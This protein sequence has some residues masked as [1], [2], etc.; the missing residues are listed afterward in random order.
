MMSSD[1]RILKYFY[2]DPNYSEETVVRT[3][4]AHKIEL[5][6]IDH[7][8]VG[9]EEIKDIIVNIKYPNHCISPEIMDSKTVDIGE[10][11]DDHPLNFHDTTEEE[12]KR[13][14]PTQL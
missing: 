11:T 3:T 9:I 1:G 8:D 6:I 12:Y 7:D 4:K 14:F 10:W 2:K 5:L 13:L